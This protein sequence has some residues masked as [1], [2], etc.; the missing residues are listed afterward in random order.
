MAFA[1]IMYNPETNLATITTKNLTFSPLIFIHTY[2]PGRI[3]SGR[4]GQEQ[5]RG[6]L[7]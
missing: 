5:L 3:S 6:T 4:V 1:C 2:L 7:R